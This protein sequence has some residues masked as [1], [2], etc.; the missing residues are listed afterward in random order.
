MAS[1]TF[2]IPFADSG[3]KAAIPDPTQPGGEVSYTEGFTLDYELDQVTEPTAKD[4]PRQE[5][6]Q[7]YFDI[8][9]FLQEIQQNGLSIYNATYDYAVGAHTIGSDGL[10]YRAL[11]VNGPA[12][13]V[14]DPVGDTS[15]SWLSN[16]G[17]IRGYVGTF[18][19][20]PGDVAKGSDDVV[21]TC[22]IANGPTSSVVD[23]VGDTTGR[24]ES[25]R[26]DVVDYVATFDYAIR[27][28][29]KGT[30]GL[31]Y[32]T[33]IV[34]GPSTSVVNP[35]GDVTGTWLSVGGAPAP[36]I[37]TVFTA[38]D[39]TWTPSAGVKALKVTVTGGGG[40]GGGAVSAASNTA[41][42][43]SGS[44]AGTGIK[45]VNAPIAASYAVV[46]GAGGSGGLGS[47]GS[48]GGDGGDSSF[49]GIGISIITGSGGNGGSGDPTPTTGIGGL[50][51]QLGGT[52][53]NGDLNIAGGNSGRM[54]IF[55]GFTTQDSRSGASYWGGGGSLIV[56]ADEGVGSPGVAYGSGGAGALTLGVA[57]R[58]GGDG[59]E[60]IVVVEEYF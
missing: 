15:G 2:T 37:T 29:A 3:D 26:A 44:A 28:Y 51:G 25:L 42:G 6:N 20:E 55:N 4:V 57:D 27:D 18:D 59:A 38:S 24:W 58:D 32:R 54:M 31:L 60:G 34:N 40:G 14:R 36:I 48:D 17:D 13:T 53:S 11:L 10:L 33:A 46:V 45:T 22:L 39:P 1:K 56:S 12:S 21:Y 16:R 23:P 7:L 43:V 47:T 30:D 5:T 50:A 41:C 19:F 35:V 8:T 52:A 9:E 49:D